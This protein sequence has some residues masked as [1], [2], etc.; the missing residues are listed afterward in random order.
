MAAVGRIRKEREDIQ[1]WPRE[2]SESDNHTWK[3]YRVNEGGHE[4]RTGWESE[5]CLVQKDKGEE[6]RRS[7]KQG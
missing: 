2:I 3:S 1:E 7:W 6:I 4:E 5:A